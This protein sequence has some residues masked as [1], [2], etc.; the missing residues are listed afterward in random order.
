MSKKKTTDKTYYVVPNL[1][2]GEVITA[3][4]PQE[5]VRKLMLSQQYELDDD[6][7]F[8]VFLMTPVGKYLAKPTYEVTKTT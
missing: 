7:D 8:E 5:A 2:D 3:S 6:D 4:S 1:R